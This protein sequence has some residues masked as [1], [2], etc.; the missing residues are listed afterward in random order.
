[1]NTANRTA[2]R[3][4]AGKNGGMS[5]RFAGLRLADEVGVSAEKKTLTAKPAVAASSTTDKASRPRSQPSRTASKIEKL[6]C[7]YCGSDDLAPSFKKRRDARCR[8]CFKKR[9]GSTARSKQATLAG[10]AKVANK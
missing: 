4:L 2:A 3:V 1:V 7:R 5:P 9:Y 6:V 10:K 8:A